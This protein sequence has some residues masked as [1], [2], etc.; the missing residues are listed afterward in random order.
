[1]TERLRRGR[2]SACMPGSREEAQA[3]SAPL[4]GQ[5]GEDGAENQRE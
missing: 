2:G 4:A 1:M 3:G 5:Q